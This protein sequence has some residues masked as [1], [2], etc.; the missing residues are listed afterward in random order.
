MLRPRRPPKP[1]VV[2]LLTDFGEQD[3]YVSSMKAVIHGINPSV[4]VVDVTHEVPSFS[5]EEAA[6]K[7]FIAR[8]VFPRGSAFVVVVDPGVGGARRPVLIVTHR[9][10]YIG[11]DNGV[12]YEPAKDD[13]IL[14]VYELDNEAFHMKPTSRTFHGRDIFTP[15]AAHIARGLEPERVGP[16]IRDYVLPDFA[17]PRLEGNRA[18]GEVMYIDGFGN[19]ITNL[20]EELL[21]RLGLRDGCELSV[22]L[23]QRELRLRLCSAYGQVGPG[24]LLAIIDSWG[25]LEVAVNLG[26]AAERLGVRPGERV[27]VAPEGSL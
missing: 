2:G 13:G 3:P 16:E 24:E 26:S 27:E 7:L 9:Y 11:P 10:Y 18:V 25:M 12:L 17:R 8:R 6:F 1:M 19:I 5:V 21:A 22:R 15:V 23:G 4:K 20:P 14:G